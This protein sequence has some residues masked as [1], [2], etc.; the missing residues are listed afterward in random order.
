MDFILK[1][2]HPIHELT[3]GENAIIRSGSVLYS[4]SS[5][6]DHFQTGHHA[7]I[8]EQSVIGSHVS[9][10]TLSDIQGDCVLGN[11]VRLHS[12]VFVP[13]RRALTIVCGFSLMRF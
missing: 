5:I 9:V 3:I 7:T 6:G 10:G 1:R 2:T 12:N 4:V 11:Y 8:R 13:I